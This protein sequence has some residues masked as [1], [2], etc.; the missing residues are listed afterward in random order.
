MALIKES[1]EVKQ[2]A[3]RALGWG[4]RWDGGIDGE[5]EKSVL[6]RNGAGAFLN[7]ESME[8]T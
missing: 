4:V 1:R 6:E 2:L 7:L 8:T 3:S 5:V